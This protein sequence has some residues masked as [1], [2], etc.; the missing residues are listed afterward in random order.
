MTNLPPDIDLDKHN[1]KDNE[2]FVFTPTYNAQ[3]GLCRGLTRKLGYITLTGDA[4]ES[5]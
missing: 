5:F 4:N 3:N 2:V 1:Y